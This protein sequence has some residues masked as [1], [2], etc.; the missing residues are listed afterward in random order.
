MVRLPSL[1]IAFLLVPAAS[2]S[3]AAQLTAAPATTGTGTHLTLVADGSVFAG[4]IPNSL[5]LRVARG[6][7]LDP[8]SVAGRC[9]DAQAA[10]AVCPSEARVGTGTALVEAGSAFGTQD[11]TANIAVFLAEPRA[12]GDLAGVVAIVELNGER[13][14]AKGRVVA[15][16]DG[17]FGLEVR[18]DSFPAPAVPPGIT[19]KLKRLEL[20]TGAERS[21]RVSVRCRK[22]SKT[23]RP[24]RKGCKGK[25][26]KL[27]KTKFVR[28]DLLTTP[29]TCAGTWPAQAF[30]TFPD[31]TSATVDAAAA[32]RE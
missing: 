12:A 18:F 16:A 9:T 4:K 21:E 29:A 8:R 15:L 17:P 27:A 19:V 3:A 24:V 5:A 10:D 7:V 28:R 32:C 22:R 20:E 6:F 26:C 31:G 14:G 23:C 2:S 25:R 13:T 11:Y 30:A 1:L